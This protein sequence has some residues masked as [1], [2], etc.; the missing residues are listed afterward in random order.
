M[1]LFCSKIV[2]TCTVAS[3]DLLITMLLGNRKRRLPELHKKALKDLFKR[4]K[5]P[6]VYVKITEL[7][8]CCHWQPLS[9]SVIFTYTRGI[10][11]LYMQLSLFL[12]SRIICKWILFISTGWF[13]CIEYA[14]IITLEINSANHSFRYYFSLEGV[15]RSKLIDFEL[16][17]VWLCSHSL[18][19][20]IKFHSL[21]SVNWCPSQRYFGQNTVRKKW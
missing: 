20:E 11:G 16:Y 18:W 13:Y 17:S 21:V 1:C 10:L 4:P 7:L 12:Q 14:V 3:F 9:N 5:I 8:S 6:W 2:C 15:N 19:T